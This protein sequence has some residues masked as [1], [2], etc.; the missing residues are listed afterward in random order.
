VTAAQAVADA[1]VAIVNALD[2]KNPAY[3]AAEDAFSDTCATRGLQTSPPPPAASVK[4][5]TLPGLAA[6]A[7]VLRR[8]LYQ[9]EGPVFDDIEACALS[10]IED[11]K[12][13]PA[14]GETRS[15]APYETGTPR[16]PR[17]S[18]PNSSSRLGLY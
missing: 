8:W 9:M 14:A 4:P 18:P 10:L 6:K 16:A 11:I 1:A 2:G 3:T 15:P 13:L 5:T 17:H 7:E 12:R